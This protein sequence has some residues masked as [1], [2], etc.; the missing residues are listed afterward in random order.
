[1]VERKSVLTAGE[2]LKVRIIVE[3]EQLGTMT[4]KTKSG[5]RTRHATMMMR[6]DHAC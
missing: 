2:N 1:M 5:S 3:D 6:I 4:S